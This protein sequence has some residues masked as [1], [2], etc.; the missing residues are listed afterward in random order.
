MTASNELSKEVED[1][2]VKITGYAQENGITVALKHTDCVRMGVLKVNGYFC[3]ADMTFAVALGRKP[4]PKPQNEWLSTF[5]HESC[6]MDQYLENSRAWR[7]TILGC[8]PS[9]LIDLWMRGVIELKPTIL[10]QMILGVLNLEL[11]CEQRSVK[12][13]KKHKLPIDITEYTQ[14]ANSYVYFYH[15]VG[16]RREWYHIGTE[17][18][19]IPEVW[20]AMPTTFNNYYTTLPVE[21]KELYLE[22][23]FN[24][25]KR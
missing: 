22:H 6:H 8:N 14:K 18:Y 16:Q 25:Q 13:I 9:E 20:Q 4:K 19:N 24:G 17:P 21:Y 10:Q 15:M 12:K 3:S 23:C 1:F 7:H 5:V 11:D 2:I